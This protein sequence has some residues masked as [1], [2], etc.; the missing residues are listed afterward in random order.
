MGFKKYYDKFGPNLVL[1][2]DG[3]VVNNE[4]LLIQYADLDRGTH[5]RRISHE[6]RNFVIL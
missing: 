6:L 3:K 1:E 2:E 4:R 5:K